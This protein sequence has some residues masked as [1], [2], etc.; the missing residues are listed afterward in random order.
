M[1]TM[2]GKIYFF[3]PELVLFGLNHCQLDENG[4]GFSF[5]LIKL[6][7][8][9]ARGGG[10]GKFGVAAAAD[11]GGGPQGPRALRP[12]RPIVPRT[13]LKF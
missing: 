11:G 8:H 4:V 13:K 1:P 12:R 3:L 10:D 7:Y 5:S 9:Q 2:T 6:Y